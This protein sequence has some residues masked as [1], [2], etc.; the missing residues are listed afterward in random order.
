MKLFLCSLHCT[1]S[2]RKVDIVLLLFI[3]RVSRLECYDLTRLDNSILAVQFQYCMMLKEKRF[4]TFSKV[5][6]SNNHMRDA[7]DVINQEI[8]GR[9][10]P[11]LLE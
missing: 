9:H 7:L 2:A 6:L 11:R 3:Q 10:V 1:I 5:L 4:K 8:W